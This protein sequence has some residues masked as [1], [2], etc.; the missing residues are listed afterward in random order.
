VLLSFKLLAI[1]VVCKHLKDV[2]MEGKNDLSWYKAT[3]LGQNAQKVGDLIFKS[4]EQT[5]NDAFIVN[6]FSLC[7]FCIS[8]LDTHFR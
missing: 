6:V 7:C 3:Q 2:N 5:S 1:P 4:V 8:K